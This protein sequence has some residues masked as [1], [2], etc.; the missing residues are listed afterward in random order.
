[1]NSSPNSSKTSDY[2]GA[3]T[4]DVAVVGGGLAG[5][6]AAIHLARSGFRVV[7]FE[8]DLTAAHKVCG[9][10]LSGEAISLLK[11]IGVDPKKIGASE[12]TTFRLHGARLAMDRKLPMKAC[13]ISRKRLDEKLLE[14]AEAEGVD[15]RRGV[16][17][18]EL[19][20]RLDSPSGSISLETSSGEI[21]A[22]RLIIATGRADFGPSEERGPRENGYVGFKMHLR[23]KPSVAKRLKRHCEFFVFDR[24]QA[25]MVPIEEDLANFCFLVE[26]KALADIGTDWES[27]AGHIAKTCWT[28]SHFLDGSEPLFKEL[29]TISFVPLGYV[30]RDPAPVGVFYVGD[31]MAQIPSITGDG[32]TIALLT[33]KR[34]AEAIVERVSGRAR[35]RFASH[36]SVRY[37]RMMRAHL[38]PQVE[39]AKY[40]QRIFRKPLFVDVAIRAARRIPGLLDA[41]ILA[42]RCTTDESRA[43]RLPFR[44]HAALGARNTVESV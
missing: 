28:A 8:K 16:L 2:Q 21:R 32:M 41:A 14:R 31:R 38:R 35:L 25:S 20:D 18:E 39:T 29:A 19:V 23:L 27:L 36:A 40:L 15:V 24:G 22:R 42:T 6:V 44:K 1:M 5:S 13:G 34:A 26:K 3:D 7:L 33:G 43:T 11:E 10:F 17:V 9:E 37:Q 4:C 30:R 12:I